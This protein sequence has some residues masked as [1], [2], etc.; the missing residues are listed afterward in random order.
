MYRGIWLLLAVGCGF[1]HGVSGDGSAATDGGTSRPDSMPQPMIDAMTVVPPDAQQCWTSP[2]VSVDVCLAAPLMGSITVSSNTSIDTDSNGTGPLQCKNLVSGSTDVCVI[3]ASSITINAARTLSASGGR[4]LV[5][6]ATSIVINGTIDVASHV[7]GQR[8]PGATSSGCDA[9]NNPDSNNGGGGQGG[10]FGTKGG[11]GGNQDGQNSSRGTAGNL[12]SPAALRGGCPGANG[13]DGGGAGG[14]GGGALLLI[15]DTITFGPGGTINA[16][17]ASGGG[18]SNGQKGGGGGGSGGM[19]AV[20]AM[21][22]TVDANAQIFAN[23][24]HG[25]GGSDQENNGSSGSDSTSPTSV[26]GGGSGAGNAGDGGAAYPASSRGGVSGSDS[27][28]GGGGGGGG[29]GIIHVDSTSSLGT[30]ISPP[31]S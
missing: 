22:I 25:G 1:E 12:L 13:G 7:G 8:G 23:G 16:S 26:G 29:A 2:T 24:G 27:S 14:D 11:D 6:I 21:M 5:L 30:N 9:G 28:D 4:P 3:A 31:A 20:S 18:A 15:A 19:I 10:S 17:G